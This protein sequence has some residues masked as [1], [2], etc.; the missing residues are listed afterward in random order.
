MLIEIYRVQAYFLIGDS[1][2]LYDISAI[3]K[4]IAKSISKLQ[5]PSP[6]V[7]LTQE[8]YE[9]SLFCTNIG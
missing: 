7:F 4:M 9:Q 5:I 3:I 8:K 1:K 2:D 6:L